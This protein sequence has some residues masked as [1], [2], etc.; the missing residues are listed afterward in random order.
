MELKKEAKTERKED[1]RKLQRELEGVKTTKIEIKMVP[2]RK[3]KN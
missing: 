1:G 3:R 2:S